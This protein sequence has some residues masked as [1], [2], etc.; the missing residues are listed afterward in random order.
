MPLPQA[1]GVINTGVLPLSHAPPARPV[2]NVAVKL[3][4][5]GEFSRFLCVPL[6]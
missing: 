3:V 2:V 4:Y 5:S 1:S 6:I